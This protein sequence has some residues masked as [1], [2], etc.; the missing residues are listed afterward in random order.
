MNAKEL[1]QLANDFKVTIP[2]T[3]ENTNKFIKDITANLEDMAKKGKF[4]KKTTCL[5]HHKDN[6]YYYQTGT[7][8]EGYTVNNLPEV[9]AVLRDQGFSVF[10]MC[11]VTGYC[12][13][14]IS[15]GN[16]PKT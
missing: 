13:F 11:K 16:I 9:I 4:E 14:N 7:G 6:E 2:N 12:P 10:F 1:N 3:M 5:V 15:W 8:G